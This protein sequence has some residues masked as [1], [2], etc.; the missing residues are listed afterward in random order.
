MRKEENGML[1]RSQIKKGAK[2]SDRSDK[3]A[4]L[5]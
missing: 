3:A 1:T 4:K 2:D 5:G